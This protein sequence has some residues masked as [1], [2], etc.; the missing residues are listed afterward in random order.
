M[1]FLFVLAGVDDWLTD[2]CLALP[3]ED[4]YT[5]SEVKL[6]LMYGSN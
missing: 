1:L 3:G 5:D 2:Q 6:H 4:F